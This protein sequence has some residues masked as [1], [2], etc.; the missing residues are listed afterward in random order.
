[1]RL[2]PGDV[3]VVICA[4]T[5]ARW[6]NLV[7][8]VASIQAQPV[9]P[10]EII[11]VVDHNSSLFER[12]RAELSGVIC[13]ANSQPQGLSGARNSGI[14]V[15]QGTIIAFIDED[16]VAAPDWLA[17]LCAGYADRQV[18]GIG[19]GIIPMWA[20]GRPF[21]FPDEFNWVVGCSYRGLPQQ[22]APVRNLIG[23]NMSFRRE[24]IQ[25]IGGFRNGVGQVG[26]SML[27]CDDT[28]FCIRL[29]QHW[30][31]A[32]FLYE[33]QAR[34][35]HHV[36]GSRARWAYFRSRCF[37]EGLAKSLIAH[38][39]GARDGLSSERTYTL[40]TLPRGIVRGLVN[41]FWRWDRAGLGQAGAIMAG[42][43]LT[44]LGYLLGTIAKKVQIFER[45]GRVTHVL[46]E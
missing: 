30:P 23:C 21:W 18:L 2:T 12:V 14:A 34:V 28:E 39:V 31:Q 36:P 40:Q 32:V 45:S 20:D 25:A 9:P 43:T 13:L 26:S 1:M 35:F 41:T 27:R 37:T 19:G 38:L 22:T 15:A 44:T 42:L 46:A 33:P 29:R 24:A 17:Q 10:L 5:Q 7:A 3:S 16:A 11:V 6:D 4:Y 8:A